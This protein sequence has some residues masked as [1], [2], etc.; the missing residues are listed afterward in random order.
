[1]AGPLTGT[2]LT[3]TE[4]A[5]SRAAGKRIGQVVIDLDATLVTAHSDKEGAKGNFKGGFGYH[6]LGAWVDNTN[7]ALAAVL[8]P[9]NAG[10]NT[11]ADYL[12]VVDWALSQLP[13]RWRGKP[14]LIRADGAGYSA[15]SA[16]C[17]SASCRRFAAPAST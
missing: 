10:S 11:A 13:D 12:T 1:M 17:G 14:I 9:G 7:E 5:G 8:R 3:G 4:L 6:P 2:E 15:P 16:A